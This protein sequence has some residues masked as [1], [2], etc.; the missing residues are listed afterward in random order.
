MW[1]RLTSFSWDPGFPSGRKLGDGKWDRQGCVCALHATVA[2]NVLFSHPSTNQASPCLASESRSNP[3]PSGRRDVIFWLFPNRQ[4]LPPETQAAPGLRA[5]PRR[6]EPLSSFQLWCRHRACR[7]LRASQSLDSGVCANKTGQGLLPPAWGSWLPGA[8]GWPKS[9]SVSRRHDSLAPSV[10]VWHLGETQMRACSTACASR[11]ACLRGGRRGEQTA[12]RPRDGPARNRESGAW[13][14]TNAD[15]N[16]ALLS[17]SRTQSLR[18]EGFRVPSAAR[19]EAQ[20][21]PV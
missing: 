19:A 17:F 15:R 21:R 20:G 18:E 4:L 10:C 6:P 7:G 16:G 1:E 2:G 13:A 9:H 11:Q 3:A 5:E 8:R 14:E 12:R